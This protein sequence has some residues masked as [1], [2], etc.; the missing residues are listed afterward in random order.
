[1]KIDSRARLLVPLPCNTL[2]R[3]DSFVTASRALFIERNC[4]RSRRCRR[5]R[6]RQ[7]VLH[8]TYRIRRERE[9]KKEGEKGR[10]WT[11]RK[12]IMQ[13]LRK[14]R[15]AVNSAPISSPPLSLWPRSFCEFLARKC[16]AHIKHAAIPLNQLP[17]LTAGAAMGLRART[18]KL[19]GNKNKIF[20]IKSVARSALAARPTFPFHFSALVSPLPMRRACRAQ[21]MRNSRGKGGRAGNPAAECVCP[22]ANKREVDFLPLNVFLVPVFCC[23]AATKDKSNRRKSVPI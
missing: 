23:S 18:S 22:V 8:K 4:R 19:D 13:I 9:E 10:E 17:I 16:C 14:R 5:R 2:T 11:Y 7:S 15:N 12:Y 1:M 20:L 6:R 3:P 21:K